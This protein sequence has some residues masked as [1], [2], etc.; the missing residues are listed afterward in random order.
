MDL[1]PMKAW[2]Q[3]FFLAFCGVL[4]DY[5]TT[6]LGLGMGFCEAC[7]K[8][9]PVYALAAFSGSIALLTLAVPRKKPR[10][11]CAI[12]LALASYLGTANNILV[13]LGISAGISL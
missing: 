7:P 11:L 2:I 12:G 9:H 8:Y 5:L 4:S 1:A 6:I 13:I 3:P 10:N